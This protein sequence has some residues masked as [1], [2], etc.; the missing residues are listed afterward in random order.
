MWFKLPD[1]GQSSV[2]FVRWVARTA[3]FMSFEICAA[4]LP[5]Y[6]GLARA[7]GICG[8]LP[9]PL[10]TSFGPTP[11]VELSID[12]VP[13]SFLVDFGTTKNIV[14]TS[15]RETARAT[16]RAA[17]NLPGLAVAD[18]LLRFDPDASKP[19]Q[20][21]GILGTDILSHLTIHLDERRA[22]VS[23][24][25]CDPSTLRRAGFKPIDQTGFFSFDPA[26]IERHRANVPVVF[27]RFGKTRVWAQLDSGYADPPASNTVDINLALFER[28]NGEATLTP[29]GTVTVSTCEGLV[30][31]PAFRSTGA[32]VII[33]DETGATLRVVNASR[34]VLKREN[35]CGGIG[36][37]TEPAAQV[38]A[39][40]LRP[41]GPVVFEPLA[42]R[43][44]IR[45]APSE[46][47]DV[48]RPP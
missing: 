6:P 18:F 24:T 21:A 11:H 10:V 48:N 14:W 37:M 40:F 22:W 1:S 23:A 43:V 41:L 26:R 28:M 3:F 7:G 38:G 34:L 25:S 32:P 13:R 16:R 27:L 35:G 15:S 47:F 36:A 29:D 5:D 45:E 8:G 12:A 19:R 33:E 2:S 30:T 42:Q 17:I 20:P 31:R 9:F 4:F 44:W 39:S 46:A